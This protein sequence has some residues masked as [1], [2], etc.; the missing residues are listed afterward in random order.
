VCVCVCVHIYIAY[1]NMY[2]LLEFVRCGQC[3]S[4]RKLRV[5]PCRILNRYS[6][7]SCPVIFELWTCQYT[8]HFLSAR[9]TCSR[10]IRAWIVLAYRRWVVTPWGGAGPTTMRRSL[11]VRTCM[12]ALDMTDSVISVP[13]GPLI[14]SCAC[15]RRCQNS[16]PC[17]SEGLI[18]I[19]GSS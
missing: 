15:V 8:P 12:L 17:F 2:C 7:P 6:T 4:R 5:H 19:T 10:V 1:W 9:P 16:M 13:S 11:T 3:E 14:I 18:S